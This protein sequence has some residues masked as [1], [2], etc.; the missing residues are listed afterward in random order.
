MV[1][2]LLLLQRASFPYRSLQLR[3]T[4]LV[5]PT[6]E[7]VFKCREILR[8]FRSLW[9][10]DTPL[11]C[12]TLLLA[13]LPTCSDCTDISKTKRPELYGA[14]VVARPSSRLLALPW[15]L[16]KSWSHTNRRPVGWNSLRMGRNS[17]AIVVVYIIFKWTCLR[18]QCGC[19]IWRT[20]PYLGL[21]RVV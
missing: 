16:I 19:R 12:E 20:L 5:W 15:W 8:P 11:A 6:C 4:S 2:H 9:F 7:T 3:Q 14:Y 13:L 18:S 21:I 17:L 1:S 10:C